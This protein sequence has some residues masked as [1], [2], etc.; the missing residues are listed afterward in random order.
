VSGLLGLATLAVVGVLFLAWRLDQYPLALDRLKPHAE[1]QLSAVSGGAEVSIGSL[2]LAREGTKFVLRAEDVRAAGPDGKPLAD[3]PTAIIHVSIEALVTEGVLAPDQV[4]LEGMSLKATIEDG[5]RVLLGTRPPAESGTSTAGADE[6]AIAARELM[7]LWQRDPRMRY[8]RLVG[9]EYGSLSVLEPGR[10]YAWR[11]PNISAAFER[12]EDGIVF[13]GKGRM[14]LQMLDREEIDRDLGTVGWVVQAHQDLDAQDVSPEISA[15]LT[16]DQVDPSILSGIIPPLVGERGLEAPVSGTMT[17]SF[18]ADTGPQA[19]AFSLELGKGKITVSDKG[20]LV[21]ERVN[22]IGKISLQD[23]SVHLDRLSLYYADA[24]QPGALQLSGDGAQLADGDIAVTADV[25]GVV[26]AW[27]ASISPA[28][29]RLDGVDAVLSGDAA[30]LFDAAGDLRNGNLRL[31]ADRSTI[32]LP[33]LFE[34][35]LVLDGI[36][37]EV[38]LKDYGAEWTLDGLE[39]DFPDGAAVR[40]EGT[41]S[42]GPAGGKARLTAAG[43]DFQLATV[44]RFWPLPVSPPAREWVVENVTGG[45][46]PTLDAVIEADIGGLYE[47]LALSNVVIDARMPLR[48]LSMTYCKP[49]PEATGIDAEAR[50]TDKL[51]EATILTGETGGMTG[52]G[53]LLRITG[54]DKGKGHEVLELNLDANGPAASLM[55]IL[56]REPLGFA[57]YLGL[58]PAVLKGRLSGNLRLVMPPIAELGLDDIEISATGRSANAFLP[59]IV[60]GRDL[61][62]AN[63]AFDVSKTD[64]RLDG[65]ARVEGVPVNV[66][67]H[68]PFGGNDRYRGRYTLIGRLDNDARRRVGL[69]GAA[70]QPPFI[71]GSTGFIFTATEGNDGRTWLDAELDLTKAALSVAPVGWKKPKGG[72]AAGKLRMVAKDG[73]LGGVE[74]FQVAGP[75]LKIAGNAKWTGENGRP[76]IRFSALKLGGGT[77]LQATIR[78]LPKEGYEIELGKGRLDL[79]PVILA[80]TGSDASMTPGGGKTLLLIKASGP[81]VRVRDGPPFH[82][83]RGSLLLQGERVLNANFSGRPG[84]GKP[85]EFILAADGGLSVNAADAGAFMRTMGLPGRIEGGVLTLTGRAAS[86]LSDIDA[87][88]DVKNFRMVEAPVMMRVLQHASITGPLELLGGSEGLEMTALE[89]PFTLKNKKLTIR[90]GRV[91]GGSLGVTF[92]GGVDIPSQV[93]D[94]NGAVVPVYV[95]NRLLSAVPLVGDVLTGG[96][97]VFAVSYSVSGQY[98]NPKVEV[99]PLSLLAPGGLRRLLLD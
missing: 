42:R 41:A 37:S 27:L 96:E 57:D 56:D 53:G 75:G 65:K 92:R 31:R 20:A 40:V 85:A 89:A 34:G 26:P 35:P 21:F 74:S 80:N 43:S 19:V 95:L 94:I 10:G 50:I 69:D 52:T 17:S 99:H 7:A 67:V 64:L 66:S 73:V 13:R 16:L 22:L 12:K 8:L 11:A 90:E 70:F 1:A 87:R 45:T 91:Y 29:S 71:D 61:D 63:L 55:A 84:G 79:R 60:G 44:K 46:V 82:D 81:S 58:E 15:E 77:D 54:I 86:D 88:L 38:T 36:R 93:V 3:I 83:V 68:M 5:G 59:G 72:Y 23:A 4:I 62:G 9:F 76:T 48:N 78:P 14:R 98:T 24:E 6:P 18:P 30:L 25:S 51:F 97:G 32:T 39:L 47:P 49:L 33:K 28:F 2:M